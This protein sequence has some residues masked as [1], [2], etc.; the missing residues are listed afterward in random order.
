MEG[1]TDRG[2]GFRVEDVGFEASGLGFSVQGTV[3][4]R[5]NGPSPHYTQRIKLVHVQ[6]LSGESWQ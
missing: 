4:I 3:N 5:L 1:L 2:L 6:Y